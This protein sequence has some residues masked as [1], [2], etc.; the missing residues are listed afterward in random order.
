MIWAKTA[1][2]VFTPPLFTPSRRQLQ[3]V[4]SRSG[5]LNASVQ[6]LMQPVVPL[7]GTALGASP[8]PALDGFRRLWWSERAEFEVRM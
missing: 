7:S 8:F 1:W 3:I 2:P 4:S 6:M 5:F